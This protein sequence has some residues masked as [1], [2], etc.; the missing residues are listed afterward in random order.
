MEIR[1]LICN[2]INQSKISVLW[3]EMVSKEYV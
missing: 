2:L 3:Q 1:N